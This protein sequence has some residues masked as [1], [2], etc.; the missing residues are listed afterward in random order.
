[1][2]PHFLATLL[3]Q[4]PIGF[5]PALAHFSLRAARHA[6]DMVLEFQQYQ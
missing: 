3:R 1:L 5:S 6:R 4:L 2:R